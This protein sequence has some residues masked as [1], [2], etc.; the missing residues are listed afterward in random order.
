MVNKIFPKQWKKI[1]QFIEVHQSQALEMIQSGFFKDAQFFNRK[2]QSLCYEIL[3]EFPEELDENQRLKL[4]FMMRDNDS[5]RDM[6]LQMEVIINLL[7]SFN[8]LRDIT[9]L[10]TSETLSYYLILEYF[11]QITHNLSYINFKRNKPGKAI[12]YI[13][14]A[15]DCLSL[16]KYSSYYVKYHLS[17]LILNLVYLID[18]N[19]PEDALTILTNAILHLEGLEEQLDKHD[20]SETIYTYLSERTENFCIMIG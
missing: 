4:F 6:R 16:I 2:L 3:K 17:T 5:E 8:K 1:I 20:D 14:Q 9:S 10:K 13:F 7:S 11:L 12:H 15:I 18:E 19:N